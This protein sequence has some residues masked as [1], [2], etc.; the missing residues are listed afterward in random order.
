[1]ATQIEGWSR[2]RLQRLIESEDVLVN[3]KPAKP[4]Y[5]LRENDELEVELIAPAAASFAPN[6]F[7]STSS[8]KTRHSSS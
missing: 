4:S 3:G 2:A 7:R 8:T 5:K 1:L 6:Q